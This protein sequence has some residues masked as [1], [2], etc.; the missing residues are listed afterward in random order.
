M[1]KN[2]NEYNIEKAIQYYNNTSY[3]VNND[4]TNVYIIVEP[5]V[6]EKIDVDLIGYF[7]KEEEAYNVFLKAKQNKH[8]FTNKNEFIN[9]II[10]I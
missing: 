10:T 7:D 2:T 4:V 6:E 5:V 9:K 1:F 8:L 3:I